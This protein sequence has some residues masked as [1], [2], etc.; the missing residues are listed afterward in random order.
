MKKTKETEKRSEIYKAN[1]YSLRCMWVA[2]LA[3]TIAWIFNVAH[4]FIVDQNIM[5]LAFFGMLFFAVLAYIVKWTIGFERKVSGYIIMFLLVAM[6]TF[7]NV[8][9]SYH[10]TLF[11]LFP[12]L[13]SV[14]YHD[15]KFG[16]YT[17]ILTAFGFLVTVLGSFYLGLCD[18]N[19]LLLTWTTSARHAKELL[20]GI[21]VINNNAVLLILFFFIPRFVALIGF[22]ALLNY[23]TSDIQ[24]KTIHEVESRRL[25]ETDALTGLNNRT[26]YAKMVETVYPSCEQV[27]VLYADINNLKC[28]NDTMGHEYG[29]VLILGLAR[30]LK[31]HEKENCISYRLGGDEFVMVMANQ[32]EE[33]ELNMLSSIRNDIAHANLEYDLVLSVAIGTAKGKGSDIKELVCKADEKM[34]VNKTEMKK[35]HKLSI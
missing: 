29:D 8:E 34:Y 24:E 9:M 12:M 32:T 35:M 18:A 4:I 14:L 5:N 33:D 16:I 3:I 23:I 28:V 25:A 17:F 22:T 11:M 15:R 1:S 26:K 7:A 21:T 30:I 2:I 27:L 20:N 13:C 19:M 10:G 31:N 6:I